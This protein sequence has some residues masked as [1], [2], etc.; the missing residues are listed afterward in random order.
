MKKEG[1]G[2]EYVDKRGCEEG[3]LTGQQMGK[4]YTRG[5]GQGCRILGEEV[6]GNGGDKSFCGGD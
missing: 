2:R 6:D 3:V 5:C 4:G 1:V